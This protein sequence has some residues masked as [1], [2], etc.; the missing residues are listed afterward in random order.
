MTPA[1]RRLRI[2]ARNAKER[3]TG[4]LQWYYLSFADETG[5]LGATVVQ[6]YGFGTACEMAHRLHCNPGG[7]A[8]GGPIDND[9][10]PPPEDRNRLLSR[11]DLAK[12]GP[13]ANVH[14]AKCDCG[15]H[16]AVFEELPGAR[17]MDEDDNS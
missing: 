17:A 13:T 2:L 14:P 5:W 11:A 4:T 10:A 12:W 3:L 7:E 6:A 16:D 9:M 15:A 8:W 1:E